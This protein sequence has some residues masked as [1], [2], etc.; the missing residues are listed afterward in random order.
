MEALTPNT[1][2]QWFAMRDLKRANA[3]LPAYKQLAEAG[4]EVFTPIATRFTVKDGKRIRV[5]SP[6]MRDLLFV[7]ESRQNLDPI[8][9]KTPTLQYR[10]KKGGKQGEPIIV[11]AEDMAKFIGAVQSTNNPKFYSAEEIDPLLCGRKIRMIG[12][13][14]DGYEGVLQTVRGSKTKHL[15]ITLPSLLAVSVDINDEFIEVL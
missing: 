1:E 14:L 12:G 8:V 6:V 10:F 15:I 7:N 11:P 5:E 2:K 4:M 9:A 3:L 13:A